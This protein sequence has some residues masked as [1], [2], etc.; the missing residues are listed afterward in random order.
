MTRL[1]TMRRICVVLI[2]HRPFYFPPNQ[3]ATLSR[4]SFMPHLSASPVLFTRRCVRS[5]GRTT[6]KTH[7]HLTDLLS[8]FSGQVSSCS[9]GLPF[10]GHAKKASGD[11][12]LAIIFSSLLRAPGLSIPRGG[13]CIVV[14][15]LDL[16]R[17]DFHAVQ[18]LPRVKTD[19]PICSSPTVE[20]I[21]FGILT[22]AITMTLCV[23]RELWAPVGSVYN[24]D[25]VLSTM[26]QVAFLRVLSYS[27]SA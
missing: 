15:R 1:L 6:G 7:S 5:L 19:V 13:N 26:V 21:F 14:F 22:G 27:C 3:A 9:P 2:F 10:R 17:Y 4:V 20:K 11:S 18:L 12:F 8:I 23:I 25:T 24:V 16:E